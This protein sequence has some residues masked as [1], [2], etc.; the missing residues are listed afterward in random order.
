MTVKP[1]GRGCDSARGIRRC[2]PAHDAVEFVLLL[3]LPDLVRHSPFREVEDI[4]QTLE[5]RQPSQHA[6]SVNDQLADHVHHAV[7]TIQRDAHRLRLRY[8]G[9]LHGAQPG[10][11]LRFRVG[12]GWLGNV[13]FWNFSVFLIRR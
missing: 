13:R 3:E 12:L 4:S 9:S 7:E 10:N 11:K 5:F 1:G 2:K 6:R 8:G